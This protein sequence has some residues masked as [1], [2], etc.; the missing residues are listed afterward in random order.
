LGGE[1]VT[2][3]TLYEVAAILTRQRNGSSACNGEERLREH[4]WQALPPA[5]A[6]WPVTGRYASNFT[7]YQPI[8]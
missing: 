6:A 5:G 2:K 8:D 3:D 7:A 4:A 1:K